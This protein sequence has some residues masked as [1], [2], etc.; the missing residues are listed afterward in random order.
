[1]E[2][3]VSALS[4]EGSSF[5]SNVPHVIQQYETVVRAALLPLLLVTCSLNIVHC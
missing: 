4:L 2:G 5:A 3:S 1:M